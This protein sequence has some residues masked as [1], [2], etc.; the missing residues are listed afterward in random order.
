MPITLDWRDLMSSAGFCRQLHTFERT[1][2]CRH[3]PK[4][5]NKI[6]IWKGPLLEI[7]PVSSSHT[8][9]WIT[10]T[11]DG[12]LQ[13]LLLNDFTCFFSSIFLQAG[14]LYLVDQ[15]GPELLNSREPMASATWR[16]GTEGIW[17]GLC[18]LYLVIWPVFPSFLVLFSAIQA[19]GISPKTLSWN[20]SNTLWS[21]QDLLIG[22]WTSDYWTSA[23]CGNLSRPD[24]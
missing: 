14:V 9:L 6:N 16:A 11:L 21:T 15:S 17:Q 5:N 7:S 3:P 4:E 22:D 13:S 20:R 12:H 19:A 8:K 1:C 23:F 18:F 10:R 2:A 24:S